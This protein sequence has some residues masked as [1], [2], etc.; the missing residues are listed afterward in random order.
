[1]RNIRINIKLLLFITV[2]VLFSCTQDLDLTNP[3]TLT[4]DQFWQNESDV[5]KAITAMYATNQYQVWGGRWGA[6]EI[7]HLT[8]EAR[9]DMVYW[10]IWQPMQ[11]IARFDISPANYMSW[12]LWKIA[13][14]TIFS[15]NQIIEN[16][17]NVPGLSAE[18]ANLYIGEAKFIR[19]ENHFMLLKNFG[20]IIIQ[21]EIAKSSDDFYKKQATKEEVWQQIENDFKDAKASLPETW[22]DQWLGRATK[23]AATAFL[24]KAYLYQEKW[25]EAITELTEVTKMGYGLVDNI[26]SLFDA[27]TDE[28]TK[29]RIFFINYTSNREGNREESITIN[30]IYR[31]SKN[32]CTDFA[33]NLFLNDTTSTGG[34]SKRFYDFVLW[35]DP[36]CDIY[37]WKGKSYREFYGPDE[38]RMFWKKWVHFHDYY[39][40]ITISD[41]DYP[42]IRYSDVLLMLAEALNESTAHTPAEAIPYVNMVRERAGSALIPETMTREELRQHIRHVERPLEFVLEGTRF[43]DLVRWY[44]FGKDGG[45]KKFLVDQGRYSAE[46]FVDGESEY[47]P[48]P[49]DEIDANPEIVQNPG[50]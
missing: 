42:I 44:G 16:V 40:H 18:Q 50:Y 2:A 49:Q 19:A 37:Y 43:Y 21:T 38:N 8:Q 45:L 15:A 13:Y 41:T 35:D 4:P 22:D 27:T 9:S 14:E 12:D 7:R 25:D 47:H 5:E 32:G 23:G 36:G 26:G 10:Q 48:I 17:P 33:K 31:D 20:N 30:N 6:G 29:E 28:N 11:G 3:N 24:G 46:S 34:F 39:E 1:M